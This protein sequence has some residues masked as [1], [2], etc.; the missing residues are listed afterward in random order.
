MKTARIAIVGGGLSG[1]YAAF[2]LEQH[3]IRDYVLLEARDA[4]GG[5]ILSVP[6]QAAGAAGL[7]DRVDLGPSW[8]WPGYQPQLS[9]LVRELGLERFEQFES[10]DI[11][12]ES[13][14]N[15]APGRVRG[16]V[17]SPA[18]MRLVG[19]MGT[20]TGALLSKWLTSARR[21][22]QS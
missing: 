1:L 19:G 8:F 11:V 16:Y 5:R 7:L 2:L 10:G 12:V 15:E 9:R 6:P 14:P 20:L 22:G 4:P 3:G 13:S 18:S 21:A 17:S